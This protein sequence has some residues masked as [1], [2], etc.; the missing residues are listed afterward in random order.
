MLQGELMAQIEG[1]LIEQLDVRRNDVAAL[2]D[3]PLRRLVLEAAHQ[4]LGRRGMPGGPA[5]D[6]LVERIADELLGMGPLESLLADPVV[7]EI[8]VNRPDEIYVERSGLIEPVRMAFS[9]EAALRRIIERVVVRAGR[10]VDDASPMVDARLADGSRINVVLPPLAVRGPAVTIRKFVRT[11]LDLG[12]LA[13]RG[14]LSGPMA[15]FLAAAVR[16]R[17]NIV[18]SGGTGSGKTTLLNAL[19]GE[20]PERERVV[21]IED[22]AEL[23]LHHRHVVVLEARPA[24]LEGEG[25]V[26]IR[27]LVRNALRMRPNRIIVGECRGG[28]ALDMLQAMNTGHE[29]SLTTAHANSPRDLL[30]RLEVMVLMAGLDLPLPAVRAQVAGA[31]DLIVHQVRLSGGERRVSS[32]VEVLGI[33][34]GVVQLQELFRLYRAPGGDGTEWRHGACGQLPACAEAFAGAN[35]PLRREW[36][37]AEGEAPVPWD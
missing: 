16:A 37:H 23:A 12:E 13:V 35:Q 36:F 5:R 14:A 2:E 22:A 6:E 11:R 32:V 10:H 1:E 9:S 26:G 27:D 25:A 15:Q 31:I 17:R 4:S 24:N 19:A 28:E 33:D 8:M 21:T 20:I 30:A 29:G 7:T 3:R 34:A 18:V